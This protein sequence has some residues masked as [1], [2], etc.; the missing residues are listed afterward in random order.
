MSF[1]CA[2]SERQPEAL[3]IG[4]CDSQ[5]LGDR[6]IARGGGALLR[7]HG[8]VVRYVGLR[9]GRMYSDIPDRTVDGGVQA[10]ALSRRSIKSVVRQAA[11]DMAW[12]WIYLLRILRALVLQPTPRLCIFGGGS[13]LM[14]NRLRFPFALAA[15]AAILRMRGVPFL[16]AGVSTGDP[17]PTGTAR[18]LIGWSLR[19]AK[20]V[21]VRDARSGR[22]VADLVPTVE[23]VEACDLAL[24]YLLE[25]PLP[26]LSAEHGRAVCC[27]MPM[28]I[29]GSPEAVRTYEHRLREL[30]MAFLNLGYEVLL[31]TTGWPSDAAVADRLR[32]RLSRTEHQDRVRLVIP[33]GEE[34]L[35]AL[36]QS[37]ERAIVSRLHAFLFAA[38]LNVPTVV[39]P[40]DGKV[41]GV[42]DALG[43][44]DVVA[45]GFMR[46]GSD[47]DIVQ[48][49]AAMVLTAD[50]EMSRLRT[51]FDSGDKELTRRISDVAREFAGDSENTA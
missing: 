23:V 38:S 3:L 44:G 37:S 30:A 12:P 1:R 2:I 35:R 28:E 14:N 41:R 45:T 46:M 42:V 31:L 29:A 40:S 8:F 51:Y 15:T 21:A 26:R 4:E 27:I 48:S 7:R 36:L 17:L 13:L 32:S 25:A 19:R 18:N 16:F 9:T 24:Y 39:V 10:A 47:R 6:A 11:V 34:H 33:N 50:G 20:F 49:A 43:A 5:N 22:F